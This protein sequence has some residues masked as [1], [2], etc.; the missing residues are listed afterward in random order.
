MV[1]LSIILLALAGIVW[2]LTHMGSMTLKIMHER[3]PLFV[4]MSDGSIQNKFDFKVLNKT[5]KDFQV[6]VTAE[7]GVKD[8]I[9][10]GAEQNPMTHHGRQASF[11][12]FV[13]APAANIVNDVVPI[14][15]RVESM[16]DSKVFAEYTSQFYGPKK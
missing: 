3:Q 9:V 2:G 11:T 14:R 8:Q 12:I 7:G 5:D 1:Y 6:R 15:F 10:V 13:K 16:D 4:Q